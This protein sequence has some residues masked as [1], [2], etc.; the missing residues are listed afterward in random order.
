[1]V[2]DFHEVL[3]V[4]FSFI[5]HCTTSNIDTTLTFLLYLD[6]IESTIDILSETDS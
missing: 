3:L 2:V 1:M 5:Q 4:S 6:I